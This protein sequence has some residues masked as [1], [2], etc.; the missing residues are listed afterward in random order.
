MNQ[1]LNA[2]TFKPVWVACMILWSCGLYF[3]RSITSYLFM[4]GEKFGNF[5]SWK[6]TSSSRNPVKELEL[7]WV[8]TISY[9]NQNINLVKALGAV[10]KM[11]NMTEFGLSAHLRN[12][13]FQSQRAVLQK[14]GVWWPLL[15]GAISLAGTGRA[16]GTHRHLGLPH[17][18]SARRGSGKRSAVTGT[19]AIN[20]SMDL[21]ARLQQW[22][23]VL[24]AMHPT[25]A[26]EKVWVLWHP[27]I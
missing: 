23:I 3:K 27:F 6:I 1:S 14:G 19:Y 13:E 11:F 18:G 7:N 16:L 22:G 17:S 2:C 21:K 25:C 5:T 20:R 26:F 10:V 24:G 4:H 9:S 8:I 12:F 15:R